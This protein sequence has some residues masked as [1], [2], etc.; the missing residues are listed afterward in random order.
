MGAISKI[1]GGGLE[2]LVCPNCGKRIEVVERSLSRCPSCGGVV[3]ITYDLQ[4]IKEKLTKENLSK[5]RPG[6]WKYAELLPQVREE[7]LVSLGEG[8]TFLHECRKLHKKI[9][10][11]A[12]YLKNETTNPTG[13]F[14]DRG[15]TVE[16]SWVKEAGVGAISCVTSSGN[17]AA[18]V[19]AYSARGGIECNI[20]IPLER[21]GELNLGKLYQVIA[22]GANVAVKDEPKPGEPRGFKVAP[23]DPF[24]AEGEKTTGYEICEQLGWSAPDRI[25]V[26]MGH[27]EHLSMIWKGINE[28]FE[29]GLITSKDV[30]MVGVQA[31]GFAPI[32]DELQGKRSRL[33]ERPRTIALDIAMAEPAYAKLAIRSI[34]DS[35]GAAVKV[36]DEEMLEAMGMLAE[37][38]GVFAEPS[39]ASTVAGVKKLVDEGAID[40][41][42]TVVCVITGAGLKDPATARKLVEKARELNKIIA[43]IESKR[44]TRRIGETKFK[45]LKIVSKGSYGYEAWKTLRDMGVR[46]D[47]SS[48][49]QHLSELEAMGLVKR[50]RVERVLGK[51]R[52]Y[53]SLTARGEKILEKLGE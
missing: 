13:S 11:R 52:C 50:S 29:L 20:L 44:F 1:W 24:F 42:E 5:R 38:E 21:V 33:P 25:V 35:K 43:R 53:Y 2:A 39:A 8:G 7:N 18:S 47:I 40:R 14:L 12:L 45:L 41:S 10:L 22:Y 37:M 32:V 46:V 23:E 26:P 31:L 9:G 6:V 16:V 36:S 27:G 48:V 4:K 49:Y 3:L 19:A 28:L 34:R 51:P 17:F 15:T 30:R